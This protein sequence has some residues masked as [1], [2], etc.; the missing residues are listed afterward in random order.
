MSGRGDRQVRAEN[1]GGICFRARGQCQP[2][3]KGQAARCGAD[4]VDEELLEVVLAR[5]D[6]FDVTEDELQLDGPAS[7]LPERR[8]CPA[9]GVIQREESR[10][11]G[12]MAAERDE[13]P[14]EQREFVLRGRRVAFPLKCIDS[15]F[16]LGSH[17]GGKAPR[18]FEPSSQSQFNLRSGLAGQIH[19]QAFDLGIGVVGRR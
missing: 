14:H 3:S 10:G 18:R 17:F 11:L 13:L 2:A 15:C 6:E 1:E 9:D 16:D 8:L 7:E 12:L 4:Y 19:D 5:R